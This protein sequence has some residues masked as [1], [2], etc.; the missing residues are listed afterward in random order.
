[1]VTIK[2]IAEEAGFSQATVSRLLKGD[3]TLSVGEETRK[4]IIN[5]ALSLGYDRSKIKTTI[6]KIAL[7][8]W[9]TNQEELQDLYF[10]QLRLSIE[11]Y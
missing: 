9:I 2:K 11:K 6:E 1:M 8:F 4:T 5:T 7:L 10:H 3:S